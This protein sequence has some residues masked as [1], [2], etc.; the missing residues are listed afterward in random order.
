PE[1]ESAA[2]D[3]VVAEVVETASPGPVTD[4]APVTADPLPALPDP[5]AREEVPAAPFDPIAEEGPI[6]LPPAAAPADSAGAP[7]TSPVPTASSLAID[8]S[9]THQVVA[10][11]ID[12]ALVADR[13][14]H[15][16]AAEQIAWSL[17]GGK[18]LVAR[19]D[20]ATRRL[21]LDAR[22]AQPGREVF[23]AQ[24]LLGTER[25]QLSLVVDVRAPRL[26]LLPFPRLVLAAGGELALDLD[27]YIQGDFAPE[28]LVWSAEIPAV[29]AVTLDAPARLLRVRESG[30]FALVLR[31]RSPWGNQ[32]EARLE[33]Q[34]AP[35]PEAP[36]PA[37]VVDSA[38]GDPSP[39]PAGVP[40]VPAPTPAAPVDPIPALADQTPPRLWLTEAA[41]GAG[42]ELRL[43]ADETLQG[44]PLL[45]VNGQAV[46]TEA[47]D[48]Q[49]RAYVELRDPQLR[50]EA[51]GV[52]LAG[53]TG[54]VARS[55]AAHLVGPG[56]APVASADGQW[57]VSFPQL[58]AR[59]WVL[60]R[61]EGVTQGLEF[62]AA[63]TGPAELVAAYT[64]TEAPAVLRDQGQGWQALPTLA[65]EGSRQ[66]F[67]RSEGGGVF[68]LGG[69][70]A[71]VLP[72]QPLVYPNPFNAQAAIRYQVGVVGMVQVQV[73]DGQGRLVR[74]LVHQAQGSGVR[75][76][77]W[78]GL[79]E[80][81]QG[82]ASGV[83]FYE[84]QVAGQRWTGK[85]LLLR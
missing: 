71:G 37:P 12:S 48:G 43:G 33:V 58:R 63:Q 47:R 17:R 61:E 32:A 19:L 22:A 49:Y 35:L 56:S 2:A 26:T 50:V 76:V 21:Y 20:P 14:V 79:D 42:I 74:E 15:Q 55:L 36:A 24:A 77:V 68:K 29:A 82:A 7:V 27:S 6:A 57:Q 18:R 39:E 9:F 44:P 84:V 65:L 46:A 85:L 64:G 28:E 75:T 72:D 62:D 59:A 40:V 31:V 23:Y 8:D 1:V 69:S 53:N 81:G 60:V 51:L 73:R 38:P 30:S 83:Y 4:P 13:W 80:H 3:P 54:Q 16:G 78:D 25:R 10:G 67:A 66:V 70:A 45:R 5:V 11:R 52:D 34:G 41:Y